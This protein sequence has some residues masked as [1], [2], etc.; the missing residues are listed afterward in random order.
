MDTYALSD[1][2]EHLLDDPLLHSALD[3]NEEPQYEFPVDVVE[4]ARLARDDQ[5]P[6]KTL[7]HMMICHPNPIMQFSEILPLSQLHKHRPTWVQV[8]L[9]IR[10]S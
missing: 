7:I 2:S 5:A 6:S 3:S 9:Q 1:M 4:D 8:T 10:I